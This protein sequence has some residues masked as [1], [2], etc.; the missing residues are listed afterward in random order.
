MTKAASADPCDQSYSIHG[1]SAVTFTF[2]TYCSKSQEREKQTRISQKKKLHASKF[3][4]TVGV[5][6]GLVLRASESAEP[7]KDL[8]GSL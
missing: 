4:E 7:N 3:E 1:C 2:H 6:A 8:V 5:E